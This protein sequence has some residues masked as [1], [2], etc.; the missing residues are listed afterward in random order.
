M[1]VL[2]AKIAHFDYTEKASNI[3]LP[4]ILFCFASLLHAL[5]YYRTANCKRNNACK[6]NAQMQYSSARLRLMY[7]PVVLHYVTV[8]GATR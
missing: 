4:C 1:C 2:Y 3:T 6:R 5:S 8:V 7:M